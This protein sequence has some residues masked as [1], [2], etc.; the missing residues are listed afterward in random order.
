MAGYFRL[1]GNPLPA[2][3]TYAACVFMFFAQY[4][5]LRHKIDRFFP[6]HLRHFACT[7]TGEYANYT[8]LGSIM[9]TFMIMLSLRT[10]A[11][12]GGLGTAVCFV[13][14]HV[15]AIYLTH[16]HPAHRSSFYHQLFRMREFKETPW[17][18]C[19]YHYLFCLTTC[20]GSVF[21]D[22]FRAKLFDTVGDLEISARQAWG[23]LRQIITRCRGGGTSRVT[24]VGRMRLQ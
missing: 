24:R 3:V 4:Y 20:L 10:I 11:I 14:S 1:H 21:F 13:A 8:N 6:E 18:C 23:G 19:K 5:L 15:F 16:Q 9:F 22:I 7:F 17:M 2:I 12:R